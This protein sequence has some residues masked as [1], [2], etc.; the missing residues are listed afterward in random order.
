MI[1]NRS[2]FYPYNS[3]FQ[4]QD[5]V[6]GSDKSKS[7]TIVA[8]AA[9]GLNKSPTFDST[10]S[11][12][13]ASILPVQPHYPIIGST[14]KVLDMPDPRPRSEQQ[15]FKRNNNCHS[16]EKTNQ[17]RGKL[18]VVQSS[19]HDYVKFNGMH[20]YKTATEFYRQTSK[21]FVADEGMKIDGGASIESKMTMSDRVQ[22]INQLKSTGSSK[23]VF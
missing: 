5:V 16:T 18:K 12:G 9:P 17:S 10:I 6:M 11:V 4:V 23:T 1:E 13:S 8:I 3:V 15:Q 14:I 22:L 20:G 2:A 19:D 21:V 7:Q